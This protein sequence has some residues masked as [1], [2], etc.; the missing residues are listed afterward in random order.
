MHI[1][2]TSGLPTIC[3]IDITP[4]TVPAIS[5]V[6]VVPEVPHHDNIVLFCANIY[7][8]DSPQQLRA[9]Q[10]HN[11]ADT[12]RHCLS[13]SCSRSYSYKPS[14]TGTAAMVCN[15][16]TLVI[17]VM[18]KSPLLRRIQT[19]YVFRRRMTEYGSG[20]EEVNVTHVWWRETHG[21]GQ[22]TNQ[23]QS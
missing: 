17:S 12:V 11:S 18:E 3:N 5:H 10:R 19:S 1:T 6:L 15:S 16:S 13:T 14:S 4:P 23:D 9:Q 8:T 7:N 20:E 21:G 22:R 2:L